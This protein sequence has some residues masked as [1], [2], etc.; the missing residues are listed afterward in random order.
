M[1]TVSG[2]PW[3][4]QLFVFSDPALVSCMMWGPSAFAD[5]C[6]CFRIEW[7][8]LGAIGGTMFFLFLQILKPADL[9]NI[10]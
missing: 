9:Q 1:S 8:G 10:L 3:C 4:V 5:A 6:G 2:D 7:W